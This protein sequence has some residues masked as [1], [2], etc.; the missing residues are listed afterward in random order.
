MPAVPAR[1]M[2]EPQSGS[3]R[4]ENHRQRAVVIALC[5]LCV[6]ALS[7]ACKGGIAGKSPENPSAVLAIIGGA[8]LRPAV[9]F[10]APVSVVPGARSSSAAGCDR[11][12][13]AAV[14]RERC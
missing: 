6:P 3:V 13:A 9:H 10:S 12:S 4:H 14:L 7:L 11:L 1:P 5:L 2:A 8:A